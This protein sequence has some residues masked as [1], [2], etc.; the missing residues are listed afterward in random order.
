MENPTIIRKGMSTWAE[1]DQ[2]RFKLKQKGLN[3][4]TTSEL[5][6][7]LLSTGTKEK[8][9]L[10]IAKDLFVQ[11]DFN[12]IELCKLSL[13]DLQQVKGI[14]LAKATTLLA[15]FELGKRRQYSSPV[16]KIVIKSSQDIGAY[17]KIALQDHNYEVF[18]VIYLNQA[19]K[20]KEFEIVSKGGITGTVVDIRLILKKAIEV[21]ATSIILSHNHPSGSLRPSQADENL[22]HKVKSA[23]AYFDIRILDHIIVSDE[24]YY[25]F[26]DDGRL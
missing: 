17:L 10:D 8:S 12:L 6:S 25:S 18:A 23:A 13:H 2:P 19:N 11:C 26:A 20:V 22:T 16:E 5:I 7:I 3:A 15:A 24:G 4:L 1:E 21:E 9:A 14:G